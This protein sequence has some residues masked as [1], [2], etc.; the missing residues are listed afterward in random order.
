MMVASYLI[1][2]KCG[3]FRKSGKRL[4]VCLLSALTLANGSAAEPEAQQPE[5]SLYDKIW[6]YA[7]WYHDQENPVLQSFSF[8]GRFQLDYALVDAD[9]GR[10][11]E[12]NIRRFRLGG[13]AKLF[14]G[15]TLHGEVD[16]NP[17]EPH[18]VYQRLTDMYLA[19][20][21]SKSFRIPGQT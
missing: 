10:H 6:R 17:Q 13:D 16:L 9:E 14:R 12:W 1:V 11:D 3:R 19:W 20:S 21:R 7:E 8:T 2:W 15:F 5:P 4:S 18:P